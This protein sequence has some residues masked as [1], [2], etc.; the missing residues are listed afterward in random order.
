MSPLMRTPSRDASFRSR[1]VSSAATKSASA[2]ARINLGD[3][4]SV[5]PMGVAASKMEP[6]RCTGWSVSLLTLI[7]CQTFRHV[8]TTNGLRKLDDLETAHVRH[9]VRMR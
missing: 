6:L 5:S 8:A 7:A 1:R 4:S 3:A 2:S 9:P